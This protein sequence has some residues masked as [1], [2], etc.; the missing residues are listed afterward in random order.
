MSSAIVHN[1]VRSVVLVAI[2]L[3]LVVGEVRADETEMQSTDPVVI[4]QVSDEL[5]RVG[6]PLN[7]ARVVRLPVDARDVIASNT[8]VADI[9]LK[10]PRMAYLIGN[11]IGTTNIIFLDAAGQQ[12]ARLDVTVAVDLSELDETLHVLVPDEDFTLVPVNDNV[13]L[14]GTVSTSEVAGNI[15]E[16]AARFVPVD[17]IVNLLNVR[18]E[19]QVLLKVRFAEV[20][21]Q[22]VKEFGIDTD[23]FLQ[24]DNF[25]F[26][27]FTGVGAVP[28]AFGLATAGW[29]SAG[30]SVDT[31]ISA[32]EQNNLVKILAE[33]TV[34][35]ISGEPASVLVG[36]EFPIPVPGQNNSVTI[37]FKS[38][39]VILEFT[40]IVLSDERISLRVNAEVSATTQQNAVTVQ[41][42]N[43]PSLIVR[44]ANTSVDLPSGGSLVIAGLLQNDINATV[45]GFPGLMDIPVLGTLFRSANFQRDE[46]ELVVLVT[47]YV[48]RPIME[49]A[50]IAAPTD[51]LAPASDLEM[52][53]LGR[54]HAVYAGRRPTPQAD[55]LAGPIGFIVE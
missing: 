10:T 11:D 33:P 52:Y 28:N 34:T 36:G 40:P 47:P 19:Q 21:R 32:L 27:L 48:V 55:E 25:S 16:I 53:F 2:A 24:S 44:R 3:L 43:I 35:A 12:I 31:A 45:Q 23:I 29:E 6:L 46:T 7:K 18:N 41:G 30:S 5:V 1:L 22:A 17:N 8:E 26:G 37:E 4:D 38:F 51:G 49:A 15:Q 50:A 39:G 20:N 13:A 42:F 54:L 9:V 14:T